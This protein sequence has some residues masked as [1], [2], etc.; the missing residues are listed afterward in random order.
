MTTQKQE[1]CK[2]AHGIAPDKAGGLER[3][4]VV[5]DVWIIGCVQMVVFATKIHYFIYICEVFGEKSWLLFVIAIFVC[6]Y[7]LKRLQIIVNICV[8][9][10]II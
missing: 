6:I 3:R 4:S 8:S 1:E 5:H 7:K 2:Q 10:L 9:R